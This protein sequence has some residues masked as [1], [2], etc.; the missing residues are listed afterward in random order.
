[1]NR[2][3]QLSGD[4]LNLSLASWLPEKSLNEFRIGNCAEVDA[5]N[6]AL[7]ND[8]DVTNIT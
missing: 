5:V 4:N 8:A 2:G 3:L 7:N 6:Q 1:M